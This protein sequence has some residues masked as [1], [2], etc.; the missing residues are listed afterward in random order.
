ME[1]VGR[2]R[3]RRADLSAA[4]RLRK[5]G[6]WEDEEQPP[7]EEGKVGGLTQSRLT[8][9]RPAG[10]SRIAPVQTV[11]KPSAVL[12]RI[13]PAFQGCK[14]IFILTNLKGEPAGSSTFLGSPSAETG[15][16]LTSDRA[17]SGQEERSAEPRI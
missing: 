7:A 2:G 6:E 11:Y 10:T 16:S 13:R 8:A 5:R 17:G 4:W 9:F 14:P 15:P 12:G 3:P 1:M